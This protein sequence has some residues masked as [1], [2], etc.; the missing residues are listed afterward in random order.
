MVQLFDEIVFS[1]RIGCKDFN[2]MVMVFYEEAKLDRVCIAYLAAE[3]NEGCE[4]LRSTK[5]LT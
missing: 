3:E 1:I 2:C 5:S 4:N